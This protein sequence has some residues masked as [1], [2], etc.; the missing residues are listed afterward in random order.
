MLMQ[1]KEKIIII[2][3]HIQ[4]DPLSKENLD[5]TLNLVNKIRLS[6]PNKTIWIYSGYT[7]NDIWDYNT[8]GEDFYGKP[9]R[10]WTIDRIQKQDIL[11]QC[12]V[13]VDGRYIDSQRDITLKWC[14]SKNQR[15]I[16]I[17][18]SLKQREVVLY[19][20]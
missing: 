12:D 11:K 4:A 17:Q 18:K 20:N 19:C 9:W 1:D 2:N 16:D 6:C 3:N 8:I 5:K 13:F 10:G 14:G 7:W 15:V